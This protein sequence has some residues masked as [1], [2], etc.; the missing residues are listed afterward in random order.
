VLGADART[1]QL[2]AHAIARLQARAPL[3]TP[4]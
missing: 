1:R 2:A 3:R 4:R